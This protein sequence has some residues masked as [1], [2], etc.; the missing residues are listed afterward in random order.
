MSGCEVLE[1]RVGYLLGAEFDDAVVV[2][3]TKCDT[4]RHRPGSYYR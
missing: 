2:L 3:L 4:E 1:F